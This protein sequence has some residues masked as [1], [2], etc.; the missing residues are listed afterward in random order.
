MDR[1]AWQATVHSEGG[2][3]RPLRQLT[4]THVIF[5][6]GGVGGPLS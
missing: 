4:H 2:V 6:E 1:G 5:S 3:D